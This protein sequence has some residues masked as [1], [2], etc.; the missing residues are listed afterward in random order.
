MVSEVMHAR[1]VGVAV[2]VLALVV[3][4][5]MVTRVTTMRRE[6]E[7]LGFPQA[8]RVQVVPTAVAAVDQAV[9]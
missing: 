5:K 4:G 1:L 2:V 3:L 6:V 9:G 7:A 8:S